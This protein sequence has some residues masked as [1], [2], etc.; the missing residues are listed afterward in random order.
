[1][2]LCQSHRELRHFFK[3]HTIQDNTNHVY[4]SEFLLLWVWQEDAPQIQQFFQEEDPLHLK[5]TQYS[6]LK[7]L[8]AVKRYCTHARKPY[9]TE[10]QQQRYDQFQKALA[11]K[12]FLGFPIC[13]EQS[14]D[15]LFIRGFMLV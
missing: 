10:T 6:I 4:L 9:F 2:G 8:N 3:L 5:K 14:G 7:T 15:F 13:R 1:M 11:Q 12:T